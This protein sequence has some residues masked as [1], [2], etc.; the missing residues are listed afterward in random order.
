MPHPWDIENARTIIDDF[1]TMRG[2]LLP[3]LHALSNRFGFVDD[4]A[5]PAL[6]AA[7][8]MTDADVYGV[9]TF[10]HDFKRT[11]PGRHTIKVCRGEACQAMGSEQM[12]AD[13]K[14][15]LDVD[16]GGVT[17]DG[18]FSLDQ[19][20][21]LGNCAL[22]PAIQLDQKLMGRMTAQRVETLCKGVGQ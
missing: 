13:I 1:K 5:I 12:L 7:F 4:S 6:A 19:V 17:A 8:N 22:S 3:A 21:C 18:Q 14:K 2:G 10:Y 9:L 11:Q 15:R 16:V 20:F